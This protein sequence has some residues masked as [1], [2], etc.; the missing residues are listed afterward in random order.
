MSNL[1]DSGVADFN[2]VFT[3]SIC[4]DKKELKQLLL[5]KARLVLEEAKELIEAIEEEDWENILKEHVDVSVTNAGVKHILS[6]NGFDVFQAEFD[7]CENN[8]TKFMLDESK[9]TVT[10]LFHKD[11]G[12]DVTVKYN[13]YWNYWYVVDMNGKLRKPVDYKDVVLSHCVP[14]WLVENSDD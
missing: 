5:S 13:D 4:N 1:I 6:E 8:L 12:L 9:A 11:K 10:K 7:V 2:D 14:N 3:K